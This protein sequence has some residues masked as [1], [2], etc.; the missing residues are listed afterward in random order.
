MS[1][2]KYKKDKILLDI[3]KALLLEIVHYKS[4]N[5]KLILSF[6]KEKKTTWPGMTTYPP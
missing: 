1:S 3:R 6:D 5:I 4:K 2:K